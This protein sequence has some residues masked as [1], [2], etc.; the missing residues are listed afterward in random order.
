MK[1][2]S[3]PLRG[4]SSQYSAKDAI[5]GTTLFTFPTSD[6]E[7]IGFRLVYDSA[8]RVYRGGSWSYSARSAR[9]ALRFRNDP[10]LRHSILGFRLVHSDQEEDACRQPMTAGRAV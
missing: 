10:T 9:V 7:N 1:R 5:G 4:G 6:H 2:K 3:K 8:D